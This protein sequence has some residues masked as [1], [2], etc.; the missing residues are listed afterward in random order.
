VLFLTFANKCYKG[1]SKRMRI[2][3]TTNKEYLLRHL[4]IC[5]VKHKISA[6]HIY[7]THVHSEVDSSG[8]LSV[9]KLDMFMSCANDR[10]FSWII[11]VFKF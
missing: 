1:N 4:A 7:L 5:E 3:S 6:K 11:T 2:L 8:L 10:Q 9:L